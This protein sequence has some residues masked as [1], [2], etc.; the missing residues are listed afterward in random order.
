MIWKL[1]KVCTH[2]RNSLSSHYLICACS[3]S[4]SCCFLMA[5]ARQGVRRLNPVPNFQGYLLFRV[6]VPV[7]VSLLWCI[8][9]FQFTRAN[10]WRHHCACLGPGLGARTLE[11]CA[12]NLCSPGLRSS[13]WQSQVAVA[14]WRLSSP[15]RGNWISLWTQAFSQIKHSEQTKHL[16]QWAQS[17]IAK[18]FHLVI[19]SVLDAFS[20]PKFISH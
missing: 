5:Q 1:L 11:M 15:H 16:W 12:W 7:R 3:W 20:S 6:R 18:Q 2:Q 19:C 14:W 8:Y 17:F 13:V 4:R 10:G 9:Y